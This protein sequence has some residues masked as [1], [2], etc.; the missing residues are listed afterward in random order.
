MNLIGIDISID[1]T[2]LSIDRNDELIICNFTTLKNNNTWI[3]KTMEYVDYE[4]INYTY[5]DVENYT[6][7]EI[8]KLREFDHISDLI[9]NKILG[10]IDKKENTIIAI[11]GYNM[12]LKNTN[13]IIDIVSF[14]TMLRLKLL[15]IPKL[16]K[17]IIISPKSIKSKACE[18]AY[19]YRTTKS[20][21]K[22][23]NKNPVG[24]SGGKFDKKQMMEALMSIDGRDK[25]SLLLNKYKDDLL[26]LKNVVKPWDDICDSYWILKILMQ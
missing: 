18:L 17:L 8:I 13:S 7:S 24:V 5:K 23:I 25:L 9:Y 3:K 4:F 2:G 15:N 11:E 21:K 16:E 12:G 6:E 14:S 20:G 26:K 22:I 10:N 1:S 19:G